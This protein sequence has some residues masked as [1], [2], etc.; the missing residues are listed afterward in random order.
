MS[1]LVSF[2]KSVTEDT[3]RYMR[4]FF[5]QN[6]AMYSILGTYRDSNITIGSAYTPDSA[7]IVYQ[8]SSISDEN[9]TTFISRLNGSFIA[10]YGSNYQIEVDRPI[11]NILNI[12]FSKIL[13]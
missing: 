1:D 3:I 13:I 6:F 8:I 5:E 9:L 12:H 4:L 11:D 2:A 7:D 10:V